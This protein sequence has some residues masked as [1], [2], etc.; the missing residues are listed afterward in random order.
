[1]MVSVLNPKKS[2]LTK[3]TAS[4]S[5]LSNCVTRF[6]PPSSQYNGEKSVSLVG[7][8]TTPPACLPAFLA[9]PSSM[10]A[11]SINSRTSSSS[12]YASKRSGLSSS[13]L[14]SVIPISNGMAF[15]NRSTNPYG[16]PNTRPT[17]LTTA[18]A[19]I[20]P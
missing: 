14:V 7:E 6:A 17:S 2:N 12:V 1:M 18:L 20:L 4:I 3:P 13:A 9:I 11:K 8:I 15:A 10:S 5:S 16:W 19:A